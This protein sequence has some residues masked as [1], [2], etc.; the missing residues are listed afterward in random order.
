MSIWLN[1]PETCNHCKAKFIHHLNEVEFK[2]QTLI[3]CNRCLVAHKLTPKHRYKKT[4]SGAR[5]ITQKSP[6]LTKEPLLDLWM[7]AFYKH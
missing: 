7:Q 6:Y 1:P 2:D 5:L 3:I 4:A